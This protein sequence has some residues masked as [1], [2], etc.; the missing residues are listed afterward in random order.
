MQMLPRQAC[1]S[2]TESESALLGCAR[3]GVRAGMGHCQ[4]DPANYGCEA[5][6]AEIIAR[7]TGTPLAAVGRRPWP[8]TTLLKQRWPT[9]Q[10]KEEL[11]ATAS[12]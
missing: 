5:R 12:S 2:S 3:A 10:Q 9:K 8:A 7:E 1:A 6:V 4:A 11:A